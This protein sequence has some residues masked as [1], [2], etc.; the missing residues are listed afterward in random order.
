M[1]KKMQVWSSQGIMEE[2]CL[3]EIKEDYESR[4]YGKSDDSIHRYLSSIIQHLY[5]NFISLITSSLATHM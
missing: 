5:A 3:Q 1:G 2:E 4:V